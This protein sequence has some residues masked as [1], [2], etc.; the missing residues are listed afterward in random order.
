MTGF[1]AHLRAA[2]YAKVAKELRALQVRREQHGTA[3]AADDAWRLMRR[4]TDKLG[5]GEDE[6]A[7]M[8]LDTARV[9]FGMHAE[10]G[11]WFTAA[12]SSLWY[13][14]AVRTLQSE[15]STREA[16]FPD[17]LYAD[18]QMMAE[19]AV[20]VAHRAGT[21]LV[22]YLVAEA[23]IGLR[24]GG[25]ASAREMADALAAPDAADRLREFRQHSRE[26]RRRATSKPADPGI[27]SV[28]T[29]TTVVEG[30]VAEDLE[31]ALERL[32]RGYLIAGSSS[33]CAV[34]AAV[35][36]G[37]S[38]VYLAPGAVAGAA[39][40]LNAP[41]TGRALCE[42]TELPGFRTD[43]VRNQLETLWTK[44]GVPARGIRDRAVRAAH[45]M[46]G[47]TVWKPLL[48]AWPDLMGSEVALV[49]L[50]ESA[51]LPLWTAPVDDSGVP[52]C[53]LMDLTVAPSGNA[54]M[55][56][57]AWP[58][59]V[60]EALVVADPWYDGPTG[61]GAMPFT[62]PE[63]RRVAAAYGVEP[64]I[65]SREAG[66]TVEERPA[67]QPGGVSPAAASAEGPAEGLAGGAEPA[68]AAEPV[69]PATLM[70]SAS[71]IH[72]IGH[73]VLEPIRPL[74]SAVLLGRPIPLSDLLRHDL[75]RGSTVV[76]SAC[77][78]GGIGTH[79]PGEQL[80]FPAALLAMGASTVVAGLWAVPDSEEAVALMGDFH[81]E[82]VR[83]TT[84]AQAFGR[85]V[86]RAAADGARPTL[87]GAFTH[88]GA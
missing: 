23:L 39:I 52:A 4:C 68:G 57:S 51:R 11:R 55:L 56:A 14:V 18:M 1:A 24:M 27:D 79:L 22:G 35:K 28:A 46:V 61:F 78:L 73:G 2:R 45:A 21:P 83:G 3:A 12:T 42:S 75:R 81:E 58:R 31:E 64:L 5:R 53:G 69:E 80:G 37:R 77:H 70:A 17:E 85:A 49:P 62:V 60:R 86:A 48:A 34:L 87:W 67:G 33:A 25:R 26:L 20:D 72:L 29:L 63:A 40:R 16:T 59:P 65:V 50:G 19:M 76:L 30:I 32:E 36:T 6:Y 43:A 15:F 82:L 9:S 54:L 38:V 7:P 41:G 88:F 71:V 8:V 47:D 84:P 10:L 74:D 13:S 44:L 66:A